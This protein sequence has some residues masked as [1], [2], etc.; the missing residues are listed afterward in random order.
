MSLALFNGSV[1]ASLASLLL[2]TRLLPPF[3]TDTALTAIARLNLS[4]PLNTTNI[5][6]SHGEQ[7]GAPSESRHS[8]PT[9]VRHSCSSTRPFL[10]YLRGFVNS[11]ATACMFD[12]SDGQFRRHSPLRWRIAMHVPAFIDLLCQKLTYRLM[13]R[14]LTSLIGLQ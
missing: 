6:P 14:M 5:H 4:L 9:V 8:G 11:Q 1:L 2:F 3:R 13:R 12:R 10:H 7:F